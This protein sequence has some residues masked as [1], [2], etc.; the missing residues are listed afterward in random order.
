M[1]PEVEVQS[2][3][4]NTSSSGGGGGSG[5]GGGGGMMRA[6]SAPDP[7]GARPMAQYDASVDVFSVGA[8]FFYLLSGQPPHGNTRL[9][10]TVRFGGETAVEAKKMAKWAARRDQKRGDEKARL[11]KAAEDAARA[12]AAAAAAAQ[13]HKSEPGS[14]AAVHEE[15]DAPEGKLP[16]IEKM[17]L[18]T[19]GGGAGWVVIGG[20]GRA[21]MTAAE[22]SAVATAAGSRPG[23]ASVLPTPATAA[24]GASAWATAA[25]APQE[26]GAGAGTAPVDA[27]GMT[28]ILDYVVRPGSLE[29]TF[30]EGM[31]AAVGAGAASSTTGGAG[32]GSEGAGA[33]GKEIKRWTAPE[34]L[35][36]LDATWPQIKEGKPLPST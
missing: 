25:A 24:M 16:A 30:L 15:R 2:S 22:A 20:T 3:A 7:A 26:Q 19:G 18:D 28:N 33:A 34:A 21:P 6:V 4:A 12:A 13:E 29:R 27:N 10:W 11:A 32:A 9:P 17:A 35:A 1:A 14:G 36:F 31:V 5:S 23:S 8:T